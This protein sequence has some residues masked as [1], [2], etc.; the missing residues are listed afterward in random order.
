ML[1]CGWAVALRNPFETKDL[2]F[3]LPKITATRRESFDVQASMT[4]TSSRESSRET[5][6]G[7]DGDLAT[8]ASENVNVAQRNHLH[9]RSN[10][11]WPRTQLRSHRTC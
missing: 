9:T 1:R 2:C 5:A 3:L 7:S 4:A 6:C 11:P 8:V 10:H